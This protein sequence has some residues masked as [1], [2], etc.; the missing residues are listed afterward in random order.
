MGDSQR[1]IFLI[2]HGEQ[3]EV[4]AGCIDWNLWRIFGVGLAQAGALL[5]CCGAGPEIVGDGF[6]PRWRQP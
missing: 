3:K 4:R 6:D 5:W 2:H 1:G